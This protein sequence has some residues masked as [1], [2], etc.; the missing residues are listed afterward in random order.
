MQ[1]PEPIQYAEPLAR[2]GIAIEKT[3]ERL[4]ISVEAKPVW[5]AGVLKWLVILLIAVCA[6]QG[7]LLVVWGHHDVTLLSLPRSVLVLGLIT[8]FF[9]WGVPKRQGKHV[10]IELTRESLRVTD[11]SDTPPT[12]R[13]FPRE[14][15]LSVYKNTLPLT[16]NF[17]YGLCVKLTGKPVA[18][19]EAVPLQLDRKSARI[20]ADEINGQLAGLKAAAPK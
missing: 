8:F 15:V 1:A 12:Q 4:L 13:T 19:T 14:E 2:R 17:G 7:L 10:H 20:L 5:W 9:L 16:G 11:L 3:P 18:K 6:A